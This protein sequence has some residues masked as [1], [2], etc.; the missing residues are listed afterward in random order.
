[1]DNDFRTRFEAFTTLC[2]MR[3]L[4]TLIPDFIIIVLEDSPALFKQ[5]RTYR[6]FLNIWLNLFFMFERLNF[7]FAGL[8]SSVSNI[9]PQIFR[10]R[11]FSVFIIKHNQ[12]IF[13]LVKLLF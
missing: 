9:A 3:G 7:F 11:M 10:T 13:R 6:S 4:I 2:R 12:I 5:K 8:D 1:M